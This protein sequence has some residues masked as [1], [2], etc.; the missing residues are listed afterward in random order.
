M[1]K[2]EFF[3]PV[4]ALVDNGHIVAVIQICGDTLA[5]LTGSDNKHSHDT[6]PLITLDN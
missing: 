5:D 1:G 6:I 2:R 4:L 3:G